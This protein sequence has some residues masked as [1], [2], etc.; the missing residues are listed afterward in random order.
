MSMNSNMDAPPLLEATT[1]AL[2]KLLDVLGEFHR[3]DP[4]LTVS[5]MLMYVHAANRPGV[6]QA[7]FQSL[8]GLVQSA[9]SRA[10]SKLSKMERH[11]CPGLDLLEAVA[12][13]RDRR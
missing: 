9:C 10:M 4:D 6:S 12:N 13:P 11:D 1:D 3:L 7:E 8:S 2:D 5:R